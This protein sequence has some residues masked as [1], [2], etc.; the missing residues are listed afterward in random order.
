MRSYIQTEKGPRG[1]AE[2]TVGPKTVMVAFEEPDENGK[3]QVFNIERANCPEWVKTGKF[4]AALNGDC[5][6]LWPLKPLGGK[7]EDGNQITYLA[8]YVDIAHDEDKPPVPR[9]DPGRSYSFI[10]KGGGVVNR[11]DPESRVFDM[12][13]RILSGF[14]KG[15]VIP[16]T[17]RYLF[18]RW[19]DSNGDPTNEAW[20][21]AEGG[22]PWTQWGRLLNNTLKVCGMDSDESPVWSQDGIGTLLSIDRILKPKRRVLT[23]HIGKSGW[24]NKVTPG[25][26]GL[27]LESFEEEE[28][29]PKTKKTKTVEVEVEEEE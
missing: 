17:L 10:G 19:E 14:Y 5:D 25:P 12:R 29:K 6:R 15:L 7:D 20:V 21:V 13:F 28:G 22:D 18:R 23:L 2:I 27:T 4:V 3:P 8:T 26:E 1:K 11:T 24:I 16:M 9:N